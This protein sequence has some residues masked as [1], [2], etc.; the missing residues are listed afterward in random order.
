MQKKYTTLF[1]ETLRDYAR[2]FPVVLVVDLILVGGNYFSGSSFFT[3]INLWTVL[4]YTL[5]HGG[6]TFFVW[7]QKEYFFQKEPHHTDTKIPTL[8]SF[9]KKPLIISLILLG[10]ALSFAS[11]VYV[12]MVLFFI[13]AYLNGNKNMLRLLVIFGLCIIAFGTGIFASSAIL[14]DGVFVILPVLLALVV[15]DM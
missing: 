7:Y 4:I 11:W 9:K 14:E 13:G 1:R 6:V 3:T 5:I 10:I 15:I 12:S 2:C 8:S